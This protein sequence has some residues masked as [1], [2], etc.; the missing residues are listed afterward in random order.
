MCA[1]RATGAARARLILLNGNEYLLCCQIL[2]RA[3][4]ALLGV[5]LVFASHSLTETFA[6]RLGGAWIFWALLPLFLLVV[7]VGTLLMGQLAKA[8]A[9]AAPERVLCRLGLPVLTAGRVVS[10]LVALTNRIASAFLS[11]F[12]VALP[13]E[14]EL[15]VSSEDISEMVERGTETGA[16]EPDEQEMIEAVFEFSDTL[17]REVMTPR[18]D[19]VAI[20]AR[21]SLEEITQVFTKER[22]SRLLVVGDTFDEVR[23]VLLA[24]D[25]IPYVGKQVPHFD[26]SRVMRRAHFVL[27]T[28]KIDDVLEQF[29]REAIHFAVVLD[30]HGGVD[31]VVTIEDLIE[32]LVGEIFDEYDVPS[33]EVMVRKLKS[34]D[35]LI[36]GM[37]SIEELNDR[38]EFDLP[39][40]EYDTLAG[41]VIHTLGRIPEVGDMAEFPPYRIRVE[42]VQNNRVTLL[43][44][45]MPRR[46]RAAATGQGK[47][48]LIESNPVASDSKRVPEG[49]AIGVGGSSSR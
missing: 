32:E 49:T 15:S 31:G 45:I 10:P 17:V 4:V 14:R 47:S 18:N 30:E 11:P 29:K 9:Y 27:S 41:F 22:L 26:I 33:D 1:Q 36:G 39:M 42:Q 37:A 40:G 38:F 7:S 3:V 6:L 23:G 20:E 44:L 24:K 46:A 43:R 19:V 16:I 5:A 13:V 12:G 2:D 28:Q 25:L 21:A 34:G 48:A 8:A 35:L